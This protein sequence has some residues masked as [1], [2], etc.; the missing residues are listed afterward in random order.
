MARILTAQPFPF[1]HFDEE[2]N[3]FTA[4]G[5]TS[6][7]YV[8]G[9]PSEM[10]R[11]YWKVKSFSVNGSY[12]NYL[13][14]NPEFPVSTSYSGSVYSDADIETELVCGAG[15]ISNLVPSGLINSAV[16]EIGFR[17]ADFYFN[18]SIDQE[19]VRLYGGL[20]FETDQDDAGGIAT[21][22]GGSLSSFKIDGFQVY[23]G[24]SPVNYDAVGLITGFSASVVASTFWQ[25]A[26]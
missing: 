25:Y 16:L 7:R 12:T 5:I 2:L 17:G 8:Q 11:L 19:V 18:S 13:F 1:S 15:T 26:P 23:L 4:C 6:G 10:M 9:T 21:A 14:N 24:G 20:T 3:D 22:V